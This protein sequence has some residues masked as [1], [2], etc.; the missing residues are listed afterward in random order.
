MTEIYL[1]HHRRQQQHQCAHVSFT[2][3]EQVNLLCIGERP[4]TNGKI[5][6]AFLFKCVHTIQ[7]EIVHCAQQTTPVRKTV[8]I[9]PT[10]QEFEFSHEVNHVRRHRPS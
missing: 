9:H 1:G 4:A 10:C 6:H 3:V 2:V 7:L 5:L 8:V